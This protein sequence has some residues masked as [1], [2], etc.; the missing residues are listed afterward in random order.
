MNNILYMLCCNVLYLLSLYNIYHINNMELLD[1]LPS[2]ELKF[3]IILF[4]QQ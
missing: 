4:Y 3:T 1:S 2:I